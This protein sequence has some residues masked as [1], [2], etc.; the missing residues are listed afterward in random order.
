MI[1]NGNNER[2]L[3]TIHPY[4]EFKLKILVNSNAIHSYHNNQGVVCNFRTLSSELNI[5]ILDIT[6]KSDIC[7]ILSILVS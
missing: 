2:P 3:T 4:S 7:Q 5:I 1:R 6:L